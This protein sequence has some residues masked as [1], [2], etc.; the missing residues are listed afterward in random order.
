M[1]RRSL[2]ISGA[3][4][5]LAR[6]WPV[7]AAE[8]ELTFRYNDSDI[9]LI[10]AALDAFEKE[11]PGVKVRAE[12]A[13]WASALPNF[14]REAAVGSGPDLI[15]SANVWVKELAEAGAVLPLDDFT[16]PDPAT[17]ALADFITLDLAEYKGKVYGS[18]WTVDTFAMV[19]NTSLMKQA[20]ISPFPKTWQ[21]LS[22]AVDAAHKSTGKAGFLLPCG[23]SAANT[24]WFAANCWWWSHGQALI[25]KKPGGGYGLGLNAG[26]IAACIDYFDGMIK[27]G[28]IPRDMLGVSAWGDP[29]VIEPMVSGDGLAI[30]VPPANFKKV[31]AEWS[32][33][34]PGG[35]PPFASALVPRASAKSTSILGGRMLVINAD[36]RHKQE[37]WKLVQFLS[38]QRFFTDFLTTQFPA[39]RRLLKDIKFGPGLQGYAAQLLQHARTWGPY[40]DGPVPIPTMW[41][42]VGRDFGAT[43]IGQ[44]T[45]RQSAGRILSVIEQKLK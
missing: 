29:A 11:N 1:R 42:E 36:T 8:V 33:R 24:I 6:P 21:E 40:S 34:H 45:S 12:R 32:K 18:P 44:S 4:A 3:A 27:D 39:E 19:Y 7:H 16:R 31:V 2:L 37:C 9:S 22:A 41:S 38:S 28:T 35:T 26:D 23:S 30:L 5:A 14:L 13:D 20:G 15:H 43:F 25:V 17:Q 10:R